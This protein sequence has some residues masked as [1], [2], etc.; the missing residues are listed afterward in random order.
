MDEENTGKVPTEAFTEWLLNLSHLQLPE[1]AIKKLVQ[2]HS[3]DS[4]VDYNDFLGGKKYIH[5]NFLLSYV[6]PF[7]MK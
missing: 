3:S 5:K 4:Q 7:F 2:A 1:D 6:F